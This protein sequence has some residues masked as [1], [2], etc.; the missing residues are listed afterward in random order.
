[1]NLTRQFNFPLFTVLLLL[2]SISGFDSFATNNTRQIIITGKVTNSG[3]GSP[4][5]N[6]E[7]FITS[8][9]VTKKNAS[10]SKTILTDEEGF[11][12]DTLVTSLNKGSVEV[13]TFDRNNKIIE[14]KLYFRFTELRSSNI[15][16]ADFSIY[17][18]YQTEQLQANFKYLLKNEND[19][20]TYQF[21]DLTT[22]EHINSWLWQFG[23]GENSGEKNPEHTFKAPGL[24]KTTLSVSA[25]IDGLNQTSSF[26]TY[27]YVSEESYFH[28]GGH[29]FAG[30]FPIDMGQAFLY[31]IDESQKFIPIDTSSFDTLGYYYFYE[32]PEGEYCIKV[33]PQSASEFYGAMVPTYYGNKVFWETATH[34]S[35]HQTN[36]EYD[37]HLVEGNESQPGACSISGN[38]AYGDTLT[39][40]RV[41]PAEGIDFYVLKEDG[42][43]LSSHYSDADGNFRFDKMENGKYWL[44]AD[45]P[46]YNCTSKLVELTDGN[47][48]ISNIE[49]IIA[50][51]DVNMSIENEGF[52][53]NNSLGKLY[54]NPASDNV[55][56]EFSA[57]ANGSVSI[58]FMDMQGRILQTEN[59]VL[60]NG[61]TAMK[62]NISTLK[63]GQ[64][65]VVLKNAGK[66]I[67]SPL[68]VSK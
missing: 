55:N 57:A 3:I 39:N 24:Y 45:I 38:V 51:G 65:I 48:E 21:T 33:Q 31:F 7:V 28:L 30:Y 34:I 25:E 12:Y 67:G 41:L 47:P 37:I 14:K 23:D 17:M 36:W 9:S 32:I 18:P 4:V 10:Y 26:S 1:M 8:E 59:R 35:H 52:L 63:N 54:P 46:G 5:A 22:N 53:K 27:I 49:I 15:F 50:N 16:V 43:L 64:Y 44:R 13:F 56:I 40:N 58:E 42:A 61:E 19:H 60:Q 29:C 68:I 6:H 62:V 66:T 2:I 20:F 11:Y